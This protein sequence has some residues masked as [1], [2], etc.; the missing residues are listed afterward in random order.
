L[1]VALERGLGGL[2]D[3]VDTVRRTGLRVAVDV[4]GDP[5]RLDPSV[6]LAAY[7]V[8]QEGLT[9]VSKHVGVNAQAAVRIEWRDGL[10]TVTVDDDGTR[11][12][13]HQSQG[14]STGHGLVGLR[15]R[16]ELVGGR[17]DS[18][19]G[20]SGGFRLTAVLPRARPAPASSGVAEHSDGH[21][22]TR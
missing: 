6:D 15:E 14:L 12:K 20:P 9:N 7:R 4:T 18:G 10:L 17:L 2:P 22:T 5:G 13:Q 1:E 16:V 21:G 19:P 11:S 8:L 3:L